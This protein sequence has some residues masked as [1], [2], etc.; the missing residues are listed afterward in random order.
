MLHR[1]RD[2]R[3]TGRV[4][5]VHPVCRCPR[6]RQRSKPDHTPTSASKRLKIKG[7]ARRPCGPS[8]G[9]KRPRR[10]A[11]PASKSPASPPVC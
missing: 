10:A 7:A 11:K 6:N 1:N 2:R 9:R 3:L 5:W 4:P 8:L